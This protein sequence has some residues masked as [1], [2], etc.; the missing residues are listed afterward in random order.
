MLDKTTVRKQKKEKDKE[1]I[2]YKIL[3]RLQDYIDVTFFRMWI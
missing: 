1:E 3:K 2:N